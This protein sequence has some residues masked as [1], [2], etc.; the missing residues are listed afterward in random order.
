MVECVQLG[1]LDPSRTITLKDLY[2]AGCV[3]SH[4]KYGVLLY[5]AMR[6]SFPLDIQVGEISA[7]SCALG[8]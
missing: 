6:L 2:D 8:A 1:L 3:T 4:I 5:G 7:A